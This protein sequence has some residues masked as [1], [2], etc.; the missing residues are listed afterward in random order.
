MLS[1]LA[2]F[3]TMSNLVTDNPEDFSLIQLGCNYSIDMASL[4]VIEIKDSLRIAEL[5]SSHKVVVSTTA[6]TIEPE[7]CC[8][9]S[10]VEMQRSEETQ[11]L[12]NIFCR[13]CLEGM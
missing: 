9:S 1:Q 5:T 11:T 6:V 8:W 10:S 3:G 2:T 13:I 7:Y 12:S 4:E